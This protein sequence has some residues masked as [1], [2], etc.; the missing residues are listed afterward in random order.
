MREDVVCLGKTVGATR[1]EMC[2]A[3]LI[4]NIEMERLL[5]DEDTLI[6]LRDRASEKALTMA[7][8]YVKDEPIFLLD[9][10]YDYRMRVSLAHKHHSD[11]GKF[12]I[13]YVTFA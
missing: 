8:D 5:N 3:N 9:R 11:C 1:K 4:A 2:K 6:D 7:D 12:K 13:R 10:R